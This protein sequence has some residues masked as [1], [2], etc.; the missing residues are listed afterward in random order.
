MVG[1][2]PC[3]TRLTDV[4]LINLFLRKHSLHLLTQHPSHPLSTLVHRDSILDR[5]WP[6]EVEKFPNVWRVGLLLG[7]LTELNVAAFLD[8]NGLSWENVHDVVEAQL[9]KRY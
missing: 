6:G 8:E 1:H 7:Y 9:T 2:V 5:V 4:N 3:E